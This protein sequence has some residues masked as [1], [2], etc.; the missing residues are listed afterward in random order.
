[1]ASGETARITGLP[2]SPRAIAWSRDGRQIAYLMRVPAPPLKLGSAPRE[3]RGRHLGR[4]L[5][6]IDRVTYRSDD[7]GY[8]KPGYDHR[9][10]R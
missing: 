9:L 4:P 5:E 6:V 2:D 3:A 8:V 7:A 1:M 10:R